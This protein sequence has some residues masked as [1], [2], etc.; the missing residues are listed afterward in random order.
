[1][2]NAPFAGSA[3]F[4]LAGILFVLVQI[5]IVAVTVME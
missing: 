2:K 3:V 4:S 5:V 1:L